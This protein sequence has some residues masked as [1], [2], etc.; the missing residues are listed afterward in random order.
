M[1][2][3][4]SYQL[5]TEKWPNAGSQAVIKSA[6]RTGKCTIMMRAKHAPEEGKLAISSGTRLYRGA[7]STGASIQ[8]AFRAL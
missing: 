2:A 7:A 1:Q 3:A 5:R 4:M 6:A 8:I